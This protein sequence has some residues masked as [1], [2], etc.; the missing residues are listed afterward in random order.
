LANIMGI[1]WVAGIVPRPPREHEVSPK[2]PTSS[3][4]HHA[5]EELKRLNDELEGYAHTVSHDLK[6]PLSAINLAN[7]M[8]REDITAIRNEH[9][10]RELENGVEV[11]GRNLTRVYSLI[12]GLLALAEAGR[13]PVEVES[14]RVADIV[15]D[16]LEERAG[17]IKEKGAKVETEGDFGEITANALQIYQVFNNIIGNA[18]VHNDS[19]DPQVTIRSKGMDSSGSH[20]FEV[21]DNGSGIAADDLEGIFRPFYKRCTNTDT[22]IGLSITQKII[23]AY[24][25]EIRAYNDNGACFEF[26][27]RDWEP[28]KAG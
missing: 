18:L 2:L 3:E 9:V 14:V 5:E 24:G 4:R 16:I 21:S 10:R 17:L 19:V 15:S 1:S 7:A 27:L 28:V 26:S 6:S 11:I 23:E 20:K 13:S 8:L 22:G 12:N 25:G